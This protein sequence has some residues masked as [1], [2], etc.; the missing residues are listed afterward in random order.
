MEE[1]KNIDLRRLLLSRKFKKIEKRAVQ[2]LEESEFPQDLPDEC[3]NCDACEQEC[4][5]GEE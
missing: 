3:D 1:K 5:T 4:E 2:P